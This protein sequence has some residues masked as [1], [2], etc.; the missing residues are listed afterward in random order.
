MSQDTDGRNAY[1]ATFTRFESTLSGN[2]S[3]WTGALR[4]EAIA[5]F[6][7]RGFPTTKEEAWRLTSVAPIARTPFTLAP[8]TTRAGVTAQILEAS[9]FEPWECSHLVFVNGR[10]A[11]DLSRLR[12]NLEGARVMNLAAALASER[13]RVEPHLARHA[14]VADHPFTALNTAF[15]QDGAFLEVPPGGIVP[16]PIHLLF[17]STTE[18]PPAMSHPRTLVVAGAG[19]QV[20][21][22]ESYVGL[23][24][25]AYFTNAVTEIVAGENAVVHHYKLQRESR[26]AYHVATLQAQIGR[27]ARFASHSV[28]LGGALVRNELNAVLDAEGGDCTLNGLYVV[29]GRQHVDNHTLIDHARPHCSSRELYKGVLDGQSRGVFEGTIV[30]RPDA[31]KTD[32]RQTNKNLLISEEALVDT[33]PQLRISADDVKCTHGATI[34]QIDEDAMFYLRAR[35]IG[36]EA[37][38]NLLIHAFVN[39]LLDRITIDPLRAGLECLLAT[40]LPRHGG[41]EAR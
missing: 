37:A 7:A 23:G 24:G 22:V 15:M 2:G 3:S 27:N 28:A 10:Y 13:G 21:L 35:G 8:G 33:K 20:T 16:E 31:Q 38:R 17:V 41:K 30:V 39:D 1:L 6:E 19:S 5:R 36:R 18:G 26:E 14:G 12:A 9:T 29:A 32:A 34:G 25:G 4:R 40:Q 11:P